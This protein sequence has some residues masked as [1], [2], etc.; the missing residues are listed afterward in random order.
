M[1]FEVVDRNLEIKVSLVRGPDISGRLLVAEGAKAPPPGTAGV[2]MRTAEGPLQFGDEGQPVTPDA[3]GNFRFS[4]VPLARQ[5]ITVSGLGESY[6]VKEI[7]YNGIPLIDNIF[8]T[9]GGSPAQSLDIVLDDKPAA[10]TGAVTDGDKPVGKP[11]VVLVKWPASPEGIFL[12][13]RRRPAMITGNSVS[14]AWHRASIAPSPCR[15]R[16]CSGWMNRAFCSGCSPGWT[17]SR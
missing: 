11:Y 17:S 8:A 9:D 10:I 13:T 14:W 7:R 1:P 12:S 15:R 3:A 2:S 16:R 6:Y 4:A 5:R